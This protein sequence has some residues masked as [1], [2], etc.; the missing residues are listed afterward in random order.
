M[1][2]PMT[3]ISRRR[4]RDVAENDRRALAS[5]GGVQMV[6]V[7]EHDDGVTSPLAGQ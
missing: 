4:R 7:L 2:G 3:Y 5:S 6:E 1:G